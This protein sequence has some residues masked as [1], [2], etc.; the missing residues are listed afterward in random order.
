M[1]TKKMLFSFMAALFAILVSFSSGFAASPH[2]TNAE[3]KQKN[4]NFSKEPVAYMAEIYNNYH[5]WKIDQGIE[6]TKKALATVDSL[7]NK[8][9]NS[10]INDP[11]LKRNRAFEIKSTLHTLLGM[12]YYRKSLDLVADQNKSMAPFMNKVEKKQQITEKDLEKLADELDK[13]KANSS[14]KKFYE[15]SMAEFRTAIQTDPKNPVPHFQLASV[16]SPAST[17]NGRSAEAE[18]ELYLA[19]KLSID[20]GDTKSAQ[21][22]AD[23]LKNLNPKSSYLTQI[24]KMIKGKQ[25]AG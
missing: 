12:L 5:N 15:A 18:K 22:A 7:Y 16:L 23:V 1:R 13:S 21:R 6:S 3:V 25:H 17:S 2:A 9:V 4:L 14:M 20:E 11:K 10:T 8:D 19:A 24:E